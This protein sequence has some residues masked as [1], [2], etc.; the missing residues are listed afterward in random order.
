MYTYFYIIL[1]VELI[2][3]RVYRIALNAKERYLYTFCFNQIV[4]H[5]KNK[6]L[7]FLLVFLGFVNTTITKNPHTTFNNIFI[8]HQLYDYEWLSKIILSSYN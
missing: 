4:F 5:R 6:L 1:K 2:V 8:Q 3:S 7:Y